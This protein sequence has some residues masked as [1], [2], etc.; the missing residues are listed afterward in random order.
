MILIT[1]YNSIKVLKTGG[2]L[3]FVASFWFDAESYGK[4][5]EETI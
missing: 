5:L 2:W 3:G 1:I 4:N